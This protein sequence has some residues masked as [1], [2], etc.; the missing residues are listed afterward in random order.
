MRTEYPIK[1]GEWKSFDLLM[2]PSG[3]DNFRREIMASNHKKA[4]VYV[5]VCDE[6]ILNQKVLRIGK[7][8]NGVIDRWVN[9]SW[10]HG[11]TFLW[12]LGET[13]HYESYADKYPNYL[14]FF[15]CLIGLKTKLH[16]ISCESTGSMNQ[17]EKDMIQSLGPIWERYKKSIRWYFERNPETK[18]PIAEWGGAKKAILSQRN[19]ESV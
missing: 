17:I 1:N 4:Q 6:G 19:G 18:Q 5:H 13:K 3:F 8:R 12:P 15:A 7:A 10:G 14:I 2:T 9:Q 11:N 16:V